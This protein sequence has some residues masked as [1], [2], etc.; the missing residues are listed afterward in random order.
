M[1]CHVTPKDRKRRAHPQGQCG[2]DRNSPRTAI[3]VGEEGADPFALRRIWREGYWQA[4]SDRAPA[5][6]PGLDAVPKACRQPQS[7]NNS[8]TMYG[9]TKKRTR[10]SG[11]ETQGRPLFDSRPLQRGC[12]AAVPE[13]ANPPAK[14]GGWHW[15]QQS[16]APTP[17]SEAYGVPSSFV[18]ANLSGSNLVLT[19][20]N[21]ATRQST[22]GSWFCTLGRR[23]LRALAQTIGVHGWKG[24]CCARGA[25]VTDQVV[26]CCRR[27]GDNGV[28]GEAQQ[29]QL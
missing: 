9:Q 20:H 1:P 3:K 25:R 14:G 15:A 19:C 23:S 2:E 26:E 12:D 29:H 7:G 18:G 4:P 27:D 24:H 22:P 28:F 5:K 6:V 10:Q 8:K 17:M 13:S 21:Q 16:R 11:R